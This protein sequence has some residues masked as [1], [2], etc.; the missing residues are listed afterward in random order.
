MN[1]ILASSSPRRQQMLSD[2][3]VHFRI[4]P[5]NIDETR[6]RGEPPIDYVLRM[7]RSK[8]AEVCKKLGLWAP[9]AAVPTASSSRKNSF[10]ALKDVHFE[11]DFSKDKDWLVLS[12][13]TIVVYGNQVLGKPRDEAEAI[14][15]LK[16][17]SG[18]THEVI[19]AFCWFGVFHKKPKFV[20]GHVRSKV[21]FSKCTPDFWKWYASTGEPL[22]KAGGYGAQ[23]LGMAFIEKISGSYSNVV[24]LPLPQVIETFRKSFGADL[25]ELCPKLH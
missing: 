20:Q 25:R 17:L 8:G 6:L 4:E 16:S 7:A 15:Y 18:H 13:D 11:K 22:D 23:G 12:A 10:A 2:F 24:G 3:G 9:S 14:K 1:F 5:S 19:T 21:T